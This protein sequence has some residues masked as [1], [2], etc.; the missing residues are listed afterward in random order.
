M[1]QR[2]DC[3]QMRTLAARRLAGGNA[4]DLG[5]QADRALHLQALVLGALDQ[6]SADLLEVLHVAAGEG[7]TDAVHLGSDILLELL[8]L[9]HSGGLHD[10][11][12]DDRTTE[13]EVRE[14][15]KVLQAA[16]EIRRPS[17]E[18]VCTNA[19]AATSFECLR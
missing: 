11:C 14:V 8:R 7:N 10:Y 16:A 17:H 1:P 3:G 2:I 4:E 15:P 9:L 13:R 19:P 5:R 18:P 6:V 12:A